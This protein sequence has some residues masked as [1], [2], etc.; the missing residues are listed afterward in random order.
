MW[1]RLCFHRPELELEVQAA[2]LRF[3]PPWIV[4]QH[5]DEVGQL[6]FDP[7][8][9]A[10]ELAEVWGHPSLP[11]TSLERCN[12]PL[13]S[14]DSARQ[15]PRRDSLSLNRGDEVLQFPALLEQLLVDCASLSTA[16][17]RTDSVRRELRAGAARWRSRGPGPP[18]TT[19]TEC[20]A[21]GGLEHRQEMFEIPS[22][23][24]E[25][26]ADDDVD[27]RSPSIEQQSIQPRPPILRPAHFIRVFSMNNPAPR[28]A[29]ATELEE[30]VLAGLGSVGGAHAGVDRG[31][32]GNTAASFQGALPVSC[33]MILTVILSSLRYARIR[34]GSTRTVPSKRDPLAACRRGNVL[35][36]DQRVI[37]FWD[38]GEIRSR[39]D[40]DA[41][42]DAS[43]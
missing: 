13:P 15:A 27:S 14:G 8:A 26:P 39:C 31:L 29:V 33:G 30:L 9:N 20:S 32:H 25:R 35:K 6:R 40:P 38:T 2:K 10:L 16:R 42:D 37:G 11:E 34:G 17:V 22:D 7:G 21:T 19:Q 24:I 41:V 36:R 5:A 18:S 1:S 12:V 28:L 43:R 3:D 4:L 23:P